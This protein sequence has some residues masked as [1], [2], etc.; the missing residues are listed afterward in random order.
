MRHV[1]HD[2]ALDFDN[3]G[4]KWFSEQVLLWNMYVLTVRNVYYLQEN[5]S[6]P[7]LYDSGVVYLLPEQLEKRPS[8][9]SLRELRKFLDE[10]M[11]MSRAEIE[12]H[13]DMARG[14]E[15]FRDIPRIMEHGGGDCDNLS[16][17]RVAELVVAGVSAKPY[18]V[19]RQ[20]G[21]R[22]IYH[23][24]CWW[25]DGSDE[26][27]SII[28]GMGGVDKR[29]ERWEECRKN[30]ER[31]SN[32][33]EQ[34]KEFL[35]DEGLSGEAREVR[36]TEIKSRIDDL[37]LLPKDGVFRVDRAP[38]VLGYSPVIYKPSL[39]RAMPGS[40]YLDLRGSL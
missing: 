35:D 24:K 30:Y 4:A 34:A 1:N 19:G 38:A 14:V 21:S 39:N 8:E 10:K 15:I 27:P 36:A 18:L 37:G 2:Y 32:Y 29:A 22:T 28:L 23:A 40:S 17:W 31:Y 26:D 9:S 5:P 16:C 11:K 12:H 3:P 25:P 7:K 33:M 13:I 6:T 20:Q